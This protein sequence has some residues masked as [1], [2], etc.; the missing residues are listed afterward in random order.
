MYVVQELCKFFVWLVNYEFQLGELK[1][2]ILGSILF[3][4]IVG[5]FIYVIVQLF[6]TNRD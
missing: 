5:L 6:G 3:A 1:F 2:T 4:G